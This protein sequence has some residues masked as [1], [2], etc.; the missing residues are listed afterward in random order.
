[1]NLRLVF[2]LICFLLPIILFGKKQKTDSLKAEMQKTT[3][4][5]V[6]VSCLEVLVPF[7][8]SI[9]QDSAIFYTEELEKLALVSKNDRARFLAAL[10]KAVNLEVDNQIEKSEMIY[11][12]ILKEIPKID[13]KLNALFYY[14]YGNHFAVLGDIEPAL[15]NYDSAI[16]YHHR[17][18]DENTV[19]RIQ[20]NVGYLLSRQSRFYESIDLYLKTIPV[21][22]KNEDWLGLSAVYGRI[23]FN[24]SRLKLH[25]EAIK[26]HNLGL[27]IDK[28]YQ[29]TENK[30]YALA[31]IASV[32]GDMRKFE[33]AWSYYQKASQLFLE[34]GNLNMLVSTNINSALVCYDQA[35][36]EKCYKILSIINKDSLSVNNKMSYEH[37]FG[38]Y[39][40][41]IGDL[42][43]ALQYFENAISSAKQLQDIKRLQEL[44]L[45]YSGAIL[46]KH[47]EITASMY[48]KEY[49]SLQKFTNANENKTAL[50]NLDKK[51]QTVEKEVEIE[52]QKLTIEKE[53]HKRNL[54]LSGVGGVLLLSSIS[55]I[56]FKNKQKRKELQSQNDLLALQKDFTDVQLS[57]LNRQLDPHE[58]KNLLA[59]ISP[60]IQEKAPE[61]YK[62]MLRLLN[63]TKASL[64]NSSLT[65]SVKIQLNQAKD[66]LALMQ[67]LLSEPLEYE[68]ENSIEDPYLQLPRLL[69]KNLVEN[70]VKHG[71][72]GKPQGGSILI[73]LDQDEEY[74]R[75]SVNDTGKGRANAINNDSGIGT[76]TYKKLFETLNT[77]NKAKASFEIIDKV[78]GTK[79]DINIPNDYKYE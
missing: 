42:K 43:Q 64:N 11:R 39:Y 77:R 31:N 53:Q 20:L 40:K 51:F 14:N 28:K 6:K 47:G 41:Q 30:A 54:A 46:E 26:Y 19:S 1:M 4:I 60:Q 18:N 50:M 44:Y 74:I 66:Y 37:L 16:K 78:E 33:E 67:P 79:V 23:G 49:D 34:I 29:F 58:I 65:E 17:I 35:N 32:Y 38:N 75:I 15:N 8:W 59:S 22:K 57:S 9:S 69:L 2:I 71:I 3:S 25:E 72:K 45:D 52:N 70:A 61:A 5:D 24:Y 63:I 48:L 62:N 68:I 36:Y 12:R 76:T 56:W 10:F 21:F 73:S 13:D 55:L 7:Y 27:A